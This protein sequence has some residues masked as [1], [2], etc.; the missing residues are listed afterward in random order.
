MNRVAKALNIKY[1]I[2]QG[3]LAWLTDAKLV[4]AVANAGESALSDQRLDKMSGWLIRIRS[5]STPQR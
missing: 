5:C 1:P 2:V 4:A 3:P